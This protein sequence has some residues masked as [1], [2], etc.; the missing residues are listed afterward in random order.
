[1]TSETAQMAFDKGHTECL[2]YALDNGCKWHLANMYTINYNKF[3]CLQV[4]FEFISKNQPNIRTK[5]P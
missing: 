5:C 2:K 1:M 4:A 3:K